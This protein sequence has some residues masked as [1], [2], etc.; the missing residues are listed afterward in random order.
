MP[1]KKPTSIS[2]RRASPRV[3]STRV[4]RSPR[5]R[6]RVPASP[7]KSPAAPRG[8]LT[9]GLAPGMQAISAYLAVANVGA[10]LAFLERALGF[11]RGVVLTEAGGQP[12]YAE[13]RHGGSVVI[14]VRKGDATTATGGL[15]ALY[16]YVDDVDRQ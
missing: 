10:S 4:K 15:P 11:T 2:R 12:R 1:T 7:S 8:G 13:M 6:R 16:A 3:T 9:S 14:L 5:T